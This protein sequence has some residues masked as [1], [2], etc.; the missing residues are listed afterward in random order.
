LALRVD[1]FLH[2]LGPAPA[3]SAVIAG[4]HGS[5]LRLT[6]SH[7]EQQLSAGQLCDNTL[8]QTLDVVRHESARFPRCLLLR[9]HPGEPE[10][11][12]APSTLFQQIQGTAHVR[13][14][15]FHDVQVDH[16]RLDVFVPQQLLHLADVFSILQ[17]MRREAVSLMPSSA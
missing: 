1:Y 5:A 6:I 15:A 16:R 9:E 11:Q 4:G 2:Q 13:G 10:K 12:N 7:V 8:V 3:Q 14:P 17:Q